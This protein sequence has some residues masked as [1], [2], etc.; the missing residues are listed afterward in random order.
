MAAHL[1]TEK[2]IWY[3]THTH[4]HGYIQYN[5]YIDV[6]MAEIR[7]YSQS[8][9]VGDRWLVYEA[10]KTQKPAEKVVKKK[11]FAKIL[12]HPASRQT[13]KRI[14]KCGRGTCVSQLCVSLGLLVFMSDH[15]RSFG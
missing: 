5:T 2:Y 6:G 9:A 7:N 14:C 3:G 13:Q 11:Y 4:T 8:K 15:A 10:K 12:I 1:C